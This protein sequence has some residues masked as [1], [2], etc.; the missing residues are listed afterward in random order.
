MLQ[1]RLGWRKCIQ[2]SGTEG[3]GSEAEEYISATSEKGQHKNR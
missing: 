2:F 1:E 3:M